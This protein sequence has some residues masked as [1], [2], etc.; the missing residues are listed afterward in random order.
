MLINV[1]KFE[2]NNKIH[3]LKKVII[4]QRNNYNMTHGKS[5]VIMEKFIDI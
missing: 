4:K 3:K 5:V 1:T 2:K